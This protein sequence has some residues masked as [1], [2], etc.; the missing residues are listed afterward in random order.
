LRIASATLPEHARARRNVT[1]ASNRP[2]LDTSQTAAGGATSHRNGKE[3]PPAS[4][5]HQ[6]SVNDKPSARQPFDPC[7]SRRIRRPLGS[8]SGVAAITFVAISR[9][10]ASPDHAKTPASSVYSTRGPTLLLGDR[11]SNRA[12]VRYVVVYRTGHLW[13]IIVGGADEPHLFLIS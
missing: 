12:K 9:A 11:L 1:P 7:S 6:R 3:S 13:R 4:D 8:T 2:C 5:S 10:R